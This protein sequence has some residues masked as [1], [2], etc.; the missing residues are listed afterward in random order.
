[1]ED[2]R[3]NIDNIVVRVKTQ[4]VI[5][6]ERYLYNRVD[7]DVYNSMSGLF[8]DYLELLQ[9]RGGRGTPDKK[10]IL[11]PYN[12]FIR[13]AIHRIK[14]NNPSM[15]GQDLMRKATESWLAHKAS[16]KVG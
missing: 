6:L 10:K 2:L 5:D 8:S 12:L 16:S 11:S 7:H 3:T 15:K 14:A 1:M 13:D 9:D 4:T